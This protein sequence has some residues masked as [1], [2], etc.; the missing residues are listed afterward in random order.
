V[1]N[2]PRCGLVLDVAAFEHGGFRQC[3]TTLPGQQGT[4][5]KMLVPLRAP[6]I[7]VDDAVAR[8]PLAPR[9]VF[10]A[11]W[12]SPTGGAVAS[13]AFPSAEPP[14]P[15]QEKAARVHHPKSDK[16]SFARS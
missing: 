3:R 13:R 15:S 8:Q 16:L 12:R 6:S 4:A 11:C 10:I 7:I 9:H 14:N 5:T 1:W 2:G